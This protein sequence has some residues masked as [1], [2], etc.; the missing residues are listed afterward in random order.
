MNLLNIKGKVD[1]WISE[2]V[3]RR[4]D[5][6]YE[7][8]VEFV[9]TIAPIVDSR[10]RKVDRWNIELLDEAIDSICDYLNGNS[11]VIVLWDEIWDAR[12]EGRSIGMD[13]I[14]MFFELI[15]RVEKKIVRE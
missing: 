5:E 8:F 14:R 6:I 7:M 13:K 1:K 15:N 3:E 10:F 4:A 2:N 9:K 12:V 11:I